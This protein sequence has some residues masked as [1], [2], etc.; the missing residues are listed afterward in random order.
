MPKYKVTIEKKT[1]YQVE[2]H[3][4]NEVNAERIA[5][6]NTDWETQS[7]KSIATKIYTVEEA[8]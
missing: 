4:D 2:V 1:F 6:Y 8:E 7:A 3:A 5:L